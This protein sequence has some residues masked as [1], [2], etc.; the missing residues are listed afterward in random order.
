MIRREFANVTVMT[1]AHRLHTI[2]DSDRVLVMANGQVDEFD[3]PSNLLAKPDGTFR[4]MVEAS[5]MA[6]RESGLH[7]GGV[8]EA[9][10]SLT[11]QLDVAEAK[12]DVTGGSRTFPGRI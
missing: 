6:K 7:V 11:G 4:G 1:I 9:T 10:S 3:T 12:E 8:H 5:R 2:I